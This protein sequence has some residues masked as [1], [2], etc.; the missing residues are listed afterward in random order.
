LNKKINV[1]AAAII[2]RLDYE[3]KI[4][5]KL[6]VAVKQHS[7]TSNERTVNSRKL[8]TGQKGQ[9]HKRPRLETAPPLPRHG[10]RREEAAEGQIISC[11]ELLNAAGGDSEG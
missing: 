5:D 11:E 8:I 7:L 9:N 6:P 3:P 2:Q 1:S 4:P 10:L